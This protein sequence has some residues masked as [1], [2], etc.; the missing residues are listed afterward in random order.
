MHGITPQ[1]LDV[2][3]DSNI[4]GGKI[5]VNRLR[6]FPLKKDKVITRLISF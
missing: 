1:M 5:E 2:Q 3:F 6:G 4:L